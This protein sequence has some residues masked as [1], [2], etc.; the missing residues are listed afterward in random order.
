L[1]QP[2]RPSSKESIWAVKPW[3][4]QPWT[5]VLTG[6]SVTGGS[7]LVFEKWWLT[8]ALAT[9]VL[10]WWWLFL[11]VVPAAYRNGKFDD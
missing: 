1:N 5:I 2:D 3:W 11:V 8:T 6:L 7:W 4:C 9:G 10:L